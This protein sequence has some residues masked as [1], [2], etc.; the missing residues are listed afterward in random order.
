MQNMYRDRDGKVEYI[1]NLKLAHLRRTFT[2]APPE[3]SENSDEFRQHVRAAVLY[4]I[5]YIVMPETS[6]SAV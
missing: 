3:I 2:V 1:T 5:G 4:V 6:G